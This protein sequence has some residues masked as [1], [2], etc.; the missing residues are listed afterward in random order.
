M[1]TPRLPLSA[2]LSQALV[3]FT[4]EVDNEFERQM[5]ASGYHGNVSLVAWANVMRFLA[6]DGA[7]VAELAASGP[8]SSD[9]LKHALG[10]LERWGLI[11]VLP[12]A[13]PPDRAAGGPARGRRAGWGSRRGIQGRSR[14]VATP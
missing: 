6:G 2:L 14:I 10:C 11:A 1:A 12:E 8:T 5:I 9:P 3:A 7:T 4:V 13:G